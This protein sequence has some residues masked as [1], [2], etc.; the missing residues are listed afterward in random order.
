[1]TTQIDLVPVFGLIV[2]LL[3]Q[4]ARTACGYGAPMTVAL[5]AE[6]RVRNVTAARG[7]YER[8]LGEPSFFPHATEV[9]WTLADDRSLY[10]EEGS[11]PRRAR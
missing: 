5:F 7:W 10:I 8:L 1:M 11:P 2:A 3:A 4:Q 9:V 6:I